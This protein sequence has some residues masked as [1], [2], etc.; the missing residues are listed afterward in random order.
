MS[1]FARPARC[2]LI[3]LET[4][5]SFACA[6]NPTAIGERR[7]VNYQRLGALQGE[8]E[9]LHYL[10]TRNRTVPGVELYADAFSGADLD[11]FRSFLT[12]LTEPSPATGAPPRVLVLWPGALRIEAV[13]TEVDIKVTQF[14]ADGAPLVLM[15]SV[16]FEEAR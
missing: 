5:E 2:T 4:A 7:E 15:A 1:T 9:E 16:T 14:A 10:F 11:A 8:R 12:R 13:V 6:F 3:N